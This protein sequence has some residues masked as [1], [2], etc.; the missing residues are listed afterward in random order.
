MH[1]CPNSRAC[2]RTKCNHKEAHEFSIVNGC[3]TT[4]CTTSYNEYVKPCIEIKY[5]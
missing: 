2:N 4:F 1:I 3:R 5:V